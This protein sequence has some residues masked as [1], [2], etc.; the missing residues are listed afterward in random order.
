VTEIIREVI[1]LVAA[2]DAAA[3]GADEFPR[4]D[5]RFGVDAK[6]ARHVPISNFTFFR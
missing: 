2:D 6:T 5:D 1:Q 3:P 4:L